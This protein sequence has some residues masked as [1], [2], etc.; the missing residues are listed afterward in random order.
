[1]G[2]LPLPE[3]RILMATI[4]SHQM[5]TLLLEIK[6]ENVLMATRIII[7]SQ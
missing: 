1:M 7:V 5:V 3:L 4:L 6:D 2:S